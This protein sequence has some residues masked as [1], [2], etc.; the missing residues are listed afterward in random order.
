MKQGLNDANPDARVYAYNNFH[1]IQE[2]NPK[3]A[4]RV[5]QECDESVHKNLNK[6]FTS[7]NT[8]ELNVTAT[9]KKPKVNKP[10]PNVEEPELPKSSPSKNR[11]K[12]QIIKSSQDTF[13]NNTSNISTNKTNNVS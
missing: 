13:D 10:I 1:L 6:T 8:K 5:W 3:L 2:F 11:V 9:I 7:L 4:A 12:P